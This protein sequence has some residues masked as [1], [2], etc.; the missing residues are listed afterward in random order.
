MI[1]PVGSMLLIKPEKR[2]DKTTASGI[3]ISAAFDDDGLRRGEVIGIGTGEPNALN[4][5]IIPVN[6]F[7]IGDRVIFPDHTGHELE[8]GT[9]KVI[10]IHHKH[11]IAKLG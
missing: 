4:G 9:E 8:D 3:L 1:K 5:E 10:V 7:E 11:I 6:G 2:E